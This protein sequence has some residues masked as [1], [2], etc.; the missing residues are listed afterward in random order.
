M[1]I[2]IDAPLWLLPFH[3]QSYH[4]KEAAGILSAR[5]GAGKRRVV[6][7]SMARQEAPSTSPA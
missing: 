7:A 2:I 5:Q 1:A 3:P 4:E 6:M